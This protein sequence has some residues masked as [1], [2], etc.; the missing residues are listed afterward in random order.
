MK[1]TITWIVISD[2]TKAKL[3]INDGPQKGVSPIFDHDFLGLN[4][5]TQ[6]IISDKQGRKYDC[7][8]SGSNIR[9]LKSDPHSKN[10][11]KFSK[12]VS[13]ILKHGFLN[14]FYDNLVLVAPAKTLGNI[15]GE[16]PE[17]LKEKIILEI[18]KD[19]THLSLNDLSKYLEKILII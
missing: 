17:E 13:E 11:K 18:R 4:L 7:S 9:E 10:K 12:K 6:D 1:P 8:L 5:L 19:L 16:L 3:L 2:A 14:K 15:R